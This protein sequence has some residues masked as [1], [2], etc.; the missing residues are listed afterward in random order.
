MMF[1][2]DDNQIRLETTDDKVEE[3]DIS[4][5]SKISKSMLKDVEG[6]WKDIKKKFNLPKG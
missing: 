3:R 1:L 5:F 6:N 4:N 2:Q